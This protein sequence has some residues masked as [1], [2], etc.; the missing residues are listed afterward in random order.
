MRA[1]P[2]T[3]KHIYSA[4]ANS[5]TRARQSA[6]AQMVTKLFT[7]WVYSFTLAII[8]D[9]PKCNENSTV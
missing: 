3:H 1:G 6:H 4:V 8:S 7:M 2:F 9:R 5:E